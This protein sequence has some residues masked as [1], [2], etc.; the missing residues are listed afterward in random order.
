MIHNEYMQE[1]PRIKRQGRQKITFP[2]SA[3]PKVISQQYTP[4][5]HTEAVHCQ[6]IL[7]GVFHPCLWPLKT[8]DPVFMT[9][10]SYYLSQT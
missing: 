3:Y 5:T 8:P 4:A 9:F 10:Q 2:G 6:R 7:L 1:Y